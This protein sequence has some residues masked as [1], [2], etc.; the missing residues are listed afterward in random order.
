MWITYTP[1]LDRYLVN[2]IKLAAPTGSGNQ[3]S[4]P[5]RKAALSIALA[6][7]AS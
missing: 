6:R 4:E 7:R 1:V 3:P 2:W 5:E